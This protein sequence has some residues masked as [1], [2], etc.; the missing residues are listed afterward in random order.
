MTKAE[1]IMSLWDGK[2]TT[3]QIARKVGCLPEYVR[4]VV[5][6]RKGRGMSENDRR[7]RQSPLGVKVARRYYEQNRE[8]LI[9]RVRE[10]MERNPEKK[11]AASSRYY[12][13]HRDQVLERLR[14][15]RAREKD[16]ASA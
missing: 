13:A 12:W 11:R 5:R 14:A 9:A 6:Q 3:G 2:R 10:W 7:Y 1:H 8:R 15:R 4:V 16:E